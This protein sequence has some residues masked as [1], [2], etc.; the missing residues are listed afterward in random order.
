MH[1]S[2]VGLITSLSSADI[3]KML[4]NSKPLDDD[5]HTVFFGHIYDTE[6]L[7]FGIL[8]ILCFNEI[9][10]RGLALEDESYQTII[11]NLSA[12]SGLFQK[13]P[14]NTPPSDYLRNP[15]GQLPPHWVSHCLQKGVL[16]VDWRSYESEPGSPPTYV[17]VKR[18]IDI[19]S[20]MTGLIDDYQPAPGSKPESHQY[21]GMRYLAMSAA[22]TAQRF[23]QIATWREQ[24]AAEIRQKQGKPAATKEV[25][26]ADPQLMR[27]RFEI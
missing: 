10:T 25:S 21:D 19:L 24:S 17:S 14:E 3:D 13:V 4:D 7:L 11:C 20:F 12:L 1:S 22:R 16:P 23:A 15:E 5:K 6:R 18:F 26:Q 8:S 2:L 9:E 27:R